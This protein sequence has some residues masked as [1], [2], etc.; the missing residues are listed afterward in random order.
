VEPEIVPNGKH[1]IHYCAQVTEKVLAAQFKAL[2]D[3]HIYL[4][5]CY[6]WPLIR[7]RGGDCMDAMSLQLMPKASGS[8]LFGLLFQWSMLSM[9]VLM[10]VLSGLGKHIEKG[11]SLAIAQV[12]TYALV[13]LLWA[14]VLYRN[15]PC[16]CRLSNAMHAMQ[17]VTE[18]VSTTLLLISTQLE[19]NT[20][21][22][23]L[24]LTSLLLTFLPIVYPM[25]MKFYDGVVVNLIVNCYRK[26][27][28]PQTAFVTITVML[29]AVPRFVMKQSSSG[30]EGSMMVAGGFDRLGRTVKAAVG[31]LKEQR[32]AE[33]Q[34]R[35]IAKA[36]CA[37][38]RA[39]RSVAR[40]RKVYPY[41][42][43]SNAKVM[44]RYSR[45]VRPGPAH[46]RIRSEA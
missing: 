38:A 20:A 28:N 8:T 34:R 25:M 4:E 10:G 39:E 31:D 44:P 21:S 17:Y 13:K 29:M 16:A 7:D 5:G 19:D 40:A 14:Y 9:Q 27:F 30:G 33:K 12:S 26:K 24:Q 36:E 3:H 45:S 32:A 11:S 23:A 37:I 2:A 35:A 15:V 46:G 43:P 6:Y 18:G 1:D 22:T 41:P 42:S